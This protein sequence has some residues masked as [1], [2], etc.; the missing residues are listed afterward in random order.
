MAANRHLRRS[1]LEDA[2]ANADSSKV[3]R[4]RSLGFISK[5]DGYFSQSSQA[6]ATPK[7]AAPAL[8]H[9]HTG[10]SLRT[11]SLHLASI[12][13][14]ISQ[15]LLI[16]VSIFPANSYSTSDLSFLV[17]NFSS[18]PPFALPVLLSNS[19]LCSL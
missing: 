9:S 3:V 19:N 14:P 1:A 13:V 4:P 12:S 11:P 10:F 2:A 16:L 7:F 6:Q 5:S 17:H 15:K 8:P 18:I